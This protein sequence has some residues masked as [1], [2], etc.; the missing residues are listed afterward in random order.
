MVLAAAILS[1]AVQ[2]AWVAAPTP[3]WAVAAPTTA[4]QFVNPVVGAANVAMTAPFRW[5]RA[6]GAK[7]YYLA[8]GTSPGDADIYGTLLSA[9]QNVAPIPPLP[10]GV[11]LW[12]RIW[13]EVPGRWS[14]GD[15][16]TFEVQA[17]R[18]TNPIP[19]TAPAVLR[20]SFRWT[21]APAAAGYYLTVGSTP[22][23]S[24]VFASFLPATTLSAAVAGLPAARTLWAR[25]W[26]RSPGFAWYPS[27]SVSF[28]TP[29]T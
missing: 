18:F 9:A 17:A 29:T 28:T 19:G 26:T 21:A 25:I 23:G 1:A 4:A 16:V 15:D 8:V 20:G 3:S 11:T 13:T 6:P 10:M 14:H 5:T 2:C 27:E 12:A 22:G 7:A 24:D